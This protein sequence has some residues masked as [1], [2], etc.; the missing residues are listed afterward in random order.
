MPWTDGK[1]DFW[2]LLRSDD[3]AWE[4]VPE[5][6]SAL[7]CGKTF[8]WGFNKRTG[9]DMCIPIES[10]G[11]WWHQPHAE[12]RAIAILADIYRSIEI[13]GSAY[14][15]VI[16]TAELKGN[17]IADRKHRKQKKVDR[18][19]WYK[20]IQRDNGT[21]FVFASDP[22]TGR[23]EPSTFFEAVDPMSI[24][25][26]ALTLPG[27]TRVDGSRRAAQDDEL[28]DEDLLVF[29]AS[30]QGFHRWVKRVAAKIANDRYGVEVSPL[31]GGSADGEITS[32]EWA[33][34]LQES[35]DQLK[36][37]SQQRRKS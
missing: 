16:E 6:K 4:G 28:S 34:C 3:F 20:T 7:S 17:L 33:P 35:W 24:A 14:F 15:A 30:G 18:P 27:V 32:D 11:T 21:T 31:A 36:K 9:L 22:L 5:T 19:V 8:I 13:T 37:E 23:D 1:P 25:A 29:G 26:A 2:A 12:Q 10:C